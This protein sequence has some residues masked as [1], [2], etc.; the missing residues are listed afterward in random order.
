[1]AIILDGTTGITTVGLTTTGNNTLGDASTDTL[2]V[3]AG[4]LVKDASGNVGVGTASPSNTRLHVVAASSGNGA[5]PLK[6]EGYNVYNTGFNVLNG[7]TQVAGFGTKAM[8]ISGATD[9]FGIFAQGTAQ[10]LLLGTGS[11]AVERAKINAFGLGIGGATPSSGMGITFPAAQ[12]ASTD[13]NTLDDYEE[14]TW[15]PTLRF[16]SAS[17]G[18]TYAVQSGVY[19]KI[20]NLVFVVA[21]IGLSSKGTS[22]GSVDISGAPFAGAVVSG[23]GAGTGGP[24]DWAS[25]NTTGPG[26]I[27]NYASTF[28]PFAANTTAITS[29]TN[30][31]FNNDTS[32]YF[33]CTYYV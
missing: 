1:M 16:G 21:R 6:L 32:L 29:M 20:G 12:S 5:G 10:T 7:A 27:T 33:S 8:F 11:P 23:C 25:F 26:V 13:A 2:N 22:T 4:G 30:A 18:I 28:T 17:V 9:E 14:G 3:G 24:L 31:N 15:T 19:T